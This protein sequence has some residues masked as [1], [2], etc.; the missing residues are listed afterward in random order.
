M[1][2]VYEGLKEA[3]LAMDC[4]SIEEI[5]SELDEYTIPENDKE[6]IDTVRKLAGNY[7]YEGIVSAIS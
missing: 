2:S 5:L 3:A 4:D 7:D 1:E 6:K